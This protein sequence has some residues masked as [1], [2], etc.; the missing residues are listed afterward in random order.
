MPTR[1]LRRLIAP[2]AAAVVLFAGAA[3]QFTSHAHADFLWCWDDPIVSVQGHL[4]EIRTGQPLGDLL[5]M[6]NTNLV[7]V[8]PKNTTG[9][10][11]LN[12]ISAFPM[13][14][15]ISA[16]G[17]AWSGSG[18]IPV[19]VKATVAAGVSYP[20]QVVGQ[21]VAS[22]VPLTVLG[23]AGSASGKTNTTI[24]MAMSLGK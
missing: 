7:V 14:T 22:L 6:R 4:L 10:V 2:L 12:D 20:V 8:I 19:T 21:P 3:P 23:A 5:T 15:T 24:T 9:S 1:L 17:P 11:V 16:T 18:A 13:T